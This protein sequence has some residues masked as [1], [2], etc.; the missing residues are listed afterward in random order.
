MTL[1]GTRVLVAGALSAD[2]GN[3]G[4]RQVAMSYLHG[5]AGP[6]AGA[7][8]GSGGGIRVVAKE[9]QLQGSVS[10]TGGSGGQA[11]VYSVHGRRASQDTMDA[12]TGFSAE[13]GPHGAPGCI[14]LVASVLRAPQGSLPVFGPTLFSRP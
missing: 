2:G 4:G 13:N 12:D 7:G 11:G 8:G 10:V 1:Q 3:R 9:V 5:Y 14:T 6:W